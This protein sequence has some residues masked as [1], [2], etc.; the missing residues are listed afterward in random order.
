MDPRPPVLRDRPWRRAPDYFASGYRDATPDFIRSVGR[1][2][3][4]LDVDG[5]LGPHGLRTPPEDVVRWMRGLRDAGIAA[6]VVSNAGERR[7]AAFCGALGV[8]YVARAG[9]PSPMP[10]RRALALLGVSPDRAVFLGDQLYTDVAGARAAGVLSV[11]V[12]PVAGRE[13]ANVVLKR[14]LERAE[15]RRAIGAEGRRRFYGKT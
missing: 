5:T 10:Y 2:A 1:D 7:M 11:L 12:P 9:K 8:P 15:I 3:L 13:P 6:A 4:L 14:L